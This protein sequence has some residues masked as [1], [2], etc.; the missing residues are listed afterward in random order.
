MSRNGGQAAGE[1][2]G[3]EVAGLAFVHVRFASPNISSQFCNCIRRHL[4][5]T[6]EEE[7]RPRK[8]LKT[9]TNGTRLR[10]DSD[11]S[12]TANQ[13]VGDQAPSSEGPSLDGED[14]A[15]RKDSVSEDVKAKHEDSVNG[16]NGHTSG[17]PLSKNQ[18][19]KLKRQQDWEAGRVHR[20]EKR[21]E[22]L[23]QKRERRRAAKEETRERQSASE[24]AGDITDQ[25][26]SEQKKTHHQR[27]TQLPITIVFDCSFDELMSEKERISLASQ[28]TR[29]YSDNH[30]APFK[31]HMVVSS[32]N[33]KLRERFEGLLGNNHHSWRGVRFLD[34]DFI[35]AAEQAKDWMAGQEGG[36]LAGALKRS[37]ESSESESSSANGE[38][39]QG[40]IIYLTSD[41][42]D[43]LTELK[44]YSTYIIGGLVDKNRHKGICH[45]RAMDRNIK[46]AKL[47]IGDYMQMASRFVLATNHVNEI[48]L[49]WLELGDW[50]EAFV[51][52]VPKRK[53]GVLKTKAS[54][55]NST[56]EVQDSELEG[57]L[58]DLHK[59]EEP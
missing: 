18:Q 40:E 36:N 14:T 29:C 52:V 32:F 59:P 21:K 39:G 24:K 34:G 20:R 46:T 13:A 55:E 19:K 56:G 16:V 26:P 41:S 17:P 51:R 31:A 57:N 9:E 53:G 27:A 25:Q 35:E 6:M 58:G 4:F 5:R 43:T 11:S 44:P 1:V 7:E 50:G 2:R 47:P 45:T 33:G 54:A 48:M 23:V 30:R 42:P 8:I 22:K 37:K 28:L 10:P 38:S 12:I 3:A 15:E 49:R